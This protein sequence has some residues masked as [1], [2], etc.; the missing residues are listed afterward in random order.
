E[1]IYDPATLRQRFKPRFWSTLV[2]DR[3]IRRE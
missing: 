2:A 1:R 3:L